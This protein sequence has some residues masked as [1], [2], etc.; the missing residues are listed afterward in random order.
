M[1]Y[2]MIAIILFEPNTPGLINPRV[3][4][5]LGPRKRKRIT[6]IDVKKTLIKI[7]KS[8]Y[9]RLSAIYKRSIGLCSSKFIKLRKNTGS[10]ES[11]EIT[12]STES[13]ESAESAKST[14]ST[15]STESTEI[16]ESTEFTES[17]EIVESTERRVIKRRGEA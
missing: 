17:K 10:T 5:V 2:L 8:L 1:Y 7:L 4:K 12:E 6:G 13:A 3:S 15:V 11:T 14:V 16:T 9:F